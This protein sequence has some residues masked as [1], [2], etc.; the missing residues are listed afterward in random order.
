MRRRRRKARSRWNPWRYIDPQLAWKAAAGI[1]IWA[2]SVFGVSHKAGVENAQS[3]QATATIGVY[4]AEQVDSLRE[5]LRRTNRRV[6]RLERE[7][8]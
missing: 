5:E 1:G 4:A 7:A 2:G 6:R 3:T 8:R